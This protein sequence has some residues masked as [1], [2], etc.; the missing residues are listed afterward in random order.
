MRQ[1]PWASADS[2]STSLRQSVSKKHAQA[3]NMT[4]ERKLIIYEPGT[5]YL[6]SRDAAHS[7]AA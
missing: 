2:S 5:T 6:L 4:D 3:Y 1:A 7:S